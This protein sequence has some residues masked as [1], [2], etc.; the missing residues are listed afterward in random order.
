MP[1]HP[2]AD[3]ILPHI[4]EEMVREA[5]K[6]AASHAAGVEV[7]KA[8]VFSD[9]EQPRLKLGEKLFRKAVGKLAVSFQNYFQVSLDISMESNSHG[10]EGRKQAG[11]R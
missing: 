8:R 7:E 6:V 4:V 9:L 11:Q 10:N 3:I 1:N 2:Y 5:V